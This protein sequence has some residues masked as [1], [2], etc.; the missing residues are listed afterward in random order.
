M[1]SPNVKILTGFRFKEEK[2]KRHQDRKKSL[3]MPD[4]QAV[5]SLQKQLLTD[6]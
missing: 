1:S 6:I 3:N 5:L 2:E 4:Y